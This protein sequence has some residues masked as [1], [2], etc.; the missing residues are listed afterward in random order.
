M[1]LLKEQIFSAETDINEMQFIKK[2]YGIRR[3]PEYFLRLLYAMHQLALTEEEKAE[4]GIIYVSHLGP[5][6]QVH[7]YV[8]DLLTYPPEQ[9]SPAYFSQSVVNA[10][11][12]FLTKYLNMNGSSLCVCGFQKIIDSSI[13]TAYSW[14]KTCYCK[15]ILLVFSDDISD[16]AGTISDLTGLKLFQSTHILL[17]ENAGTGSTDNGDTFT[18]KKLIEKIKQQH[19]LCGGHLN[20]IG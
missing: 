4:T 9:C 5:V 19:N 13:L 2:I 14:L 1:H 11:V 6:K 18:V 7:K 15:K 3:I 17:L 8:D 10:P 20:D 16:I 12:A